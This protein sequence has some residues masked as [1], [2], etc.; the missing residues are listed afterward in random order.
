LFGFVV[1]FAI[2]SVSQE[3]SQLGTLVLK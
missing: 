3:R 2:L 1:A